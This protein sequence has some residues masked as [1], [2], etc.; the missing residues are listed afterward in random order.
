MVRVKK[1]TH[2][3]LGLALEQ[4]AKYYRDSEWLKSAAYE[5]DTC[6]YYKKEFGDDFEY[7][8]KQGY[9]YTYKKNYLIACD[10]VKLKK[11]YPDIYEKWFGGI[12]DM[13]EILN[14]S[15]IKTLFITDFGPN[16]GT[17]F[18]DSSYELI[19]AFE[20]MYKEYSIYTMAPTG[21]D[22]EEFSKHTETT[23][24]KFGTG[25]CWKW[26]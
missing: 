7:V 22:V 6:E 26:C 9:C 2:G 20:E 24:K 25:R 4:C 23:S 10:P 12:P 14:E 16:N 21:V 1:L 8:W 17:H 13:E 5:D 18:T 15:K 3:E 19:N 11:D